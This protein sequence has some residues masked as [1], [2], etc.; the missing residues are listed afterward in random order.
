MAADATGSDCDYAHGT[1]TV[2]NGRP[3]VSGWLAA[4][5]SDHDRFAVGHVYN[6]NVAF[7]PVVGVEFANR[8]SDL[9][10]RLGYPGVVPR[11]DAKVVLTSDMAQIRAFALGPG[12]ADPG[13]VADVCSPG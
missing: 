7:T 12:G 1:G 11:E 4:L 6:E 3:S 8:S 2:Y 5:I 13:A 9:L 10:T